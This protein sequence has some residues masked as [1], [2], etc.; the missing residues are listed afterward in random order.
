MPWKTVGVVVALL[1]LVV[2]ALSLLWLAGEAHYQSC[3]ARI[4]ARYPATKQVNRGPFKPTASN[5][6]FRDVPNP[7]RNR[8][9]NCSRLPF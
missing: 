4:E 9:E 6:S 5:V 2:T 7:D 8:V 3:V 1:G